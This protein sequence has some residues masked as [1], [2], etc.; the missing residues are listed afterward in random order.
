MSSIK[1]LIGHFSIIHGTPQHIG[2]SSCRILPDIFICGLPVQQRRFV[3]R[4]HPSAVGALV[5][6]KDIEG[7]RPL[8]PFHAEEFVAEELGQL[9]SAPHTIRKSRPMM[10]RL[11]LFHYCTTMAV[12]AVQVTHLSDHTLISSS[13]S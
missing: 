7:L 9:Q 6:A 3:L 2:T 1:L 12:Q 8:H 11:C 4:G 5:G 10:G 13:V